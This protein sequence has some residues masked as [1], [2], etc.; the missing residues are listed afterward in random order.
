MAV[1]LH[2]VRVPQCSQN[3]CLNEFHA[4]TPGLHGSLNSK[5]TRSPPHAPPRISAG[6]TP[7]VC[8]SYLC[9][10]LLG[11]LREGLDLWYKQQQAGKHWVQVGWPGF[12]PTWQGAILQHRQPCWTT[13][14]HAWTCLPLTPLAPLP[15]TA[16]CA[17]LPHTPYSSPQ[18]HCNSLSLSVHSS[19]TL[20]FSVMSI[21]THFVCAA[22]CS[23]P[24]TLQLQLLLQ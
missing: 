16:R 23:L 10:C 4:S 15:H 13:T 22:C 19:F 17:P 20:V 2:L 14:L 21:L 18:L 1:K 11:L 9:L 12:C 7:S 3:S 8:H 6:R 5:L 24:I